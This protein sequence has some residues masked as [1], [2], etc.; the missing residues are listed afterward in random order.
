MSE[1]LKV[2]TSIIG[3]LALLFLLCTTNLVKAQSGNHN[4]GHAEHHDIYKTWKVP[5]GRGMSCCNERKEKE[6]G[7]IEGDCRPVRARQDPNGDWE[8]FVDGKWLSIPPDKVLQEKH[9]DG[10][11]HYCGIADYTFCFAPGEVRS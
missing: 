8:A 5:N 4:D 7:T 10:R 2:L 3:L 6:D 9:P 1:R 11:S